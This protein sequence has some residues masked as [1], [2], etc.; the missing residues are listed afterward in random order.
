M[1]GTIARQHKNG[2]VRLT[3][4]TWRQSAGARSQ[5]LALPP[6]MPALLTR[7]S[8]LPKRARV[9]D[10]AASMLPSSVTSTPVPF[11]VS[12]A[13]TSAIVITKAAA[14]RSHSATFA[15]EARRRSAIAR[16]MPRAAPV[17]TATRPARSIW[18]T[19]LGRRQRLGGRLGGGVEREVA[20]ARTE[21]VLVDRALAVRRRQR[22]G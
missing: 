22:Q 15:P 7:M 21:L 10:T 17:T 5:L 19:L 18:F 13:P 2:P 14:S 9:A 11:T 4:S 6:V 16:P 20:S 3:S 12:T 8:I 1:A